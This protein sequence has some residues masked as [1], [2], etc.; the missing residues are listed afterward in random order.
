ME[1]IFCLYLVNLVLLINHEIDAAYWQEWKLVNAPIGI[2]GFV[3]LHFPLLFI[4]LYGLVLVE[5]GAAAGYPI[6]LAMAAIGIFAPLAHAW[7]LWTGRPEFR[8]VMSIFILGAMFVMSIL[9]LGV[10]LRLMEIV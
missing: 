6:S 9:Q 10:T 4:F 8:S 3:G 5:K 7:F 2:S 1:I